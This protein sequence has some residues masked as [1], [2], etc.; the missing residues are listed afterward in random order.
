M[1]DRDYQILE[2]LSQDRKSTVAE[3]SQAL[4]V[5]QVTIRKDLDQLEKQDIIIR[6]HGSARLKSTE[7]INGRIANHYE[8]KVGIAKE[9]A[10]LIKDGDIVMIESGSS[11]ALL[12][13]ELAA[14]RK[15]LTIITNNAYIASHI[16][17][18][19]NNEVILLGGIMQPDSLTMT[20]P[21]V[22]LCAENFFVDYCFAG[23]DGWSELTG[24]CNKDQM[25]GQ[26]VRD[27]AR[28]CEACVI[29]TEHEKFSKRGNIPL[30]LKGKVKL[31][32]TD[33]GLDD[34][35]KERLEAAGLQVIRAGHG[36]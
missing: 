3:L 32:I 26:A 6:E 2:L 33:A 34:D 19:E 8:A 16:P 15:N 31:V 24:F 9:A 30:N 4:G 17:Q 5:S 1:K 13:F 25:R 35:K 7:N 22:A 14:T 21:M 18:K 28:Q 11:C 27:M 29:L 12:A 20:G 36:I 10:K 23:T